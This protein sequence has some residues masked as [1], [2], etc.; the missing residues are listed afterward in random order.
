MYKFD[1]SFFLHELWVAVTY[2]PLTLKLSMIPMVFGLV[3]GTLLAILRIQKVPVLNTLIKIYIL[4]FRSM[5]MVLM[6]LILYFSFMYGFDTIA[7]LMH[8]KIRSGNVPPI[9]LAYIILS[10]VSVAFMTESIRTAL[11]SVQ[12]GQV[13]AAHSIGMKTS[14]IYRRIIIP[15]ALPVAIPILGNTF[16]G[17]TKGTALVY[18]IGV[19]DLITGVKIEANAS[20]RYL[21][22]YIAIAVIYWLLCIAIEQGIRLLSHRV[23]AVS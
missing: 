16:I 23:N 5:P 17:L 18:M 22:A 15:Q 7:E 1:Y 20:Y 12:K 8:L 10:I 4:I 13:E 9:I 21:E 11:Q 14:A 3:F 2:I 19:T 6:I